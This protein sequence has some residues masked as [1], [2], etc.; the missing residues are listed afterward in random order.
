MSYKLDDIDISSYDAFPYVGQTKDSKD[1]IAISGVFDLPKRKGTTEYNWGTSIEP[2]VDAEDIELDG[3][4]LV[5]SLVVRSEKVKSQLDKLKKA[6]I[7]CR[8]LSTGFGS[9]NVICKDEIY[10][11]EYVSLNMAI[12]QVKFWQQSYIPAEIGINPSGGNNYVMDGYSLNANFGIYV[13]SRSGVETVGKRIEI[14]TTLPY[15][16]NE[17]REPTTL[18]LKCTMLGNS[19]EWLYSSM[20][21]FSALCISPG[22]RNLILKGNER[23][24]IYFKDGITVT[25]RTKHVLDF[26][27]KCRVM[28]Q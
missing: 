1:C 11:E 8:R 27:L 20:S 15:M 13:S 26:D 14:G 17:Y 6:C 25:V 5:L 21:Q 12:V 28:Q 22:L 4:T 3:R 23:L 18:T 16:Q 19:L 24:E 2:F 10:V 9:F 7:S